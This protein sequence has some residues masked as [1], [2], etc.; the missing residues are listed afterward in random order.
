MNR[1]IIS[2]AF[3]VFFLSCNRQNDQQ[4]SVKPPVVNTMSIVKSR[5]GLPVMTAGRIAAKD[6]LKLSFKK[7]GVIEDVFV[8]EGETV[9]KGQLLARL[10][11]AEFVSA[12]TQAELVLDKA[13]RDFNRISNLYN[14]SVATLEQY[15]NAKTSLGLAEQNLAGTLFNIEH[16]AIKSPGNGK[17]LKKLASREEIVAEG[18]PVI[19]FGSTD[20][21]WVLKTSVSDRDVVRIDLGDSANVKLDAWPGMNF[22]ASVA[23]ISGM[24]DPYT[25]TFNIELMLDDHEENLVSGMIGNAL[26]YPSD[27]SWFWLFPAE[28]LVEGNGREAMIYSV[29]QQRADLL[30]IHI[31]AI[32][33]DYMYSKDELGDTL[34][35]ITSGHQFV[36]DGM[37]VRTVPENQ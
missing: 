2:T 8:Q 35:I 3:L 27:S 23:E 14:D 31:E 21:H 33:G 17:I 13:T 10:K 20:S 28:S 1:V 25:G 30:T 6:E 37:T 7:G 24:A 22:S 15:Q 29:Q 5:T 12:R 34:R 26:V 16:T 19:L 32:R 36:T 4:L 18:M 11:Q 9:R